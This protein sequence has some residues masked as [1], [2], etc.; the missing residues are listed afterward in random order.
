MFISLGAIQGILLSIN[1]FSVV[2]AT[3]FI[4]TCSAVY[5]GGSLGEEARGGL[6]FA[7]HEQQ[8]FGCFGEGARLA[9]RPLRLRE[10]HPETGPAWAAPGGG[11]G[12][13]QGHWV[14]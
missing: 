3:I 14:I 5:P 1:A 8:R 11:A 13:V 7:P 10:S 12:T 2:L 4:S 6:Q 9:Q